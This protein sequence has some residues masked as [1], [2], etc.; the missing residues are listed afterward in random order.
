MPYLHLGTVLLG[1][2]ATLPRAR[3]HHLDRGAHVLV[4]GQQ[5]HGRVDATH[6]RVRA[7]H[8]DPLKLG[9]RREGLVL[10]TIRKARP[11]VS[12]ALRRGTI[13]PGG[14]ASLGGLS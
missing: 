1:A 13:G 4:A 6:A 5:V 14:L 7:A 8:R 2:G 11:E 12:D 3:P 10:G 9:E